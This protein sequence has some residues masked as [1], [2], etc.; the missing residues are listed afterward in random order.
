MKLDLTVVPHLP[1]RLGDDQAIDEPD[2][3]VH[4]NVRPRC[5]HRAEP[6]PSIQS[7]RQRHR[8]RGGEDN[9]EITSTWAVVP[10]RTCERTRHGRTQKEFAP[11]TT[12]SGR[13]AMCG[14]GK[15][16]VQGYFASVH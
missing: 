3:T 13:A 6:L 14:C 11:H 12:V 9:D 4:N 8:F 10:I 2:G 16:D 1:V 15:E 7:P 5:Q